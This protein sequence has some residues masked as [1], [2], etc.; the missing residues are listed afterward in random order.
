[1]ANGLCQHAGRESISTWNSSQP[2]ATAHIVAGMLDRLHNPHQGSNDM[3]KVHENNWYPTLV[4]G[5]SDRIK[6][7]QILVLNFT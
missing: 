3:L 5:A 1:M 6:I 4:G 2:V 7:T